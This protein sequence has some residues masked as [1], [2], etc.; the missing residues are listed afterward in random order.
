VNATTQPQGG[1]C[2]QRDR[3]EEKSTKQLAKIR[4]TK[5]TSTGG[6]GIVSPQDSPDNAIKARLIAEMHTAK[7][8]LQ[9]AKILVNEASAQAE[10]I[11]PDHPE[12]VHTLTVATAE[13]DCAINQYHTAVNSFA[14]F[15]LNHTLSS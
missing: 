8:E 3:L 15:I 7:E 4:R 10:A 6:T 2:C 9:R 11:E 13:Y 1:S 12:G 14:D 5:E